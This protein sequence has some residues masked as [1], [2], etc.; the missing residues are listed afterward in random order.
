MITR[1]RPRRHRKRSNLPAHHAVRSLFAEALEARQLLTVVTDVDPPAN[2]HLAPLSAN[3]A[4]TFD[5][6]IN[7]TTATLQ[8]FSIHSL[9]RGQLGAADATIATAGNVVTIDP[10]D[11][12]AGELVQ[13]TVTSATQSAAGEAATPF[14][15]QFRAA[16]TSGGAV[17][18]P[19]DPGLGTEESLDVAVGDLDGDGD[20]DAF[21]AN[22][23]VGNRVWLNDRGVFTDSGQRLGDHASFGVALGDLDGDGDL[24]A[25]VANLGQANR[26]WVN[27]GGSFTDSGQNLGG[28][29]SLD[30]ALG[31]LDGDGDLDAFVANVLQG[32]RVWT[33]EGGVFSS[34]Q[35]LGS[36]SSNAVSLGD[37]D[38]DGDLDAFVANSYQANRVW[39]NDG[40]QFTDSGQT[41]GN[42]SSRSVSLG[43]VDADG[44]LD[45]FVANSYQ[46]SRLWTNSSG[47]F[48]ESGQSFLN[49]RSYGVSLGDLDADGD[50]DALVAN[51]GSSNS[52]L[53]NDAGVFTADGQPLGSAASSGI[54]LGDLDLDGDLDAV[55]ANSGQNRVWLN[56]NP[57]FF[58]TPLTASL[59]EGNADAAT[60]SFTVT[61]AFDTR[62][63]ASVDFAVTPTGTDPAE[64]D[65][66]GGAVLPNGTLTFSDG[67]GTL[68]IDIQIAGDVVLENDEAFLVTLSNPVGQNSIIASG[69]AR[70]LIR[71]DDAVDLGDL[72][73][74]FPTLL[75]DGGA[76]HNA[77]GP[78]LGAT[79]DIDA[80]GQPAPAADGDDV[81]GT[82]DDEDGVTFTDPPLAGQLTASVTVNASANAALDAWIDFDGDQTFG[83]A[84]EQIA[85][86]QNVVTG[87][88]VVTFTVPPDA[89]QGQTFARFRLSSMGGLPPNGG[90]PDGE[91]EDH[92]LTI[93]S[94]TGSGVFGD[95]GQD[96][97]NHSTLA[98]ALG[99]LD[100]D[101]DLDAFAANGHHE[102]DRVWLNDGGVFT[103]SG[104]NLGDRSNS[105]VAL[106]DLDGDGDLDALVT[107]DEG[108]V[109]WFNAAGVFSESGQ[110]LGIHDSSSVAL[111][112]LDADGDLDAF[113][114]NDGQGNQLWLNDGGVFSNSGQQLGSGAS[115]S[116]SLG[117][118]DGDG[119]LDAFVANY[120][121][122]NKIWRNDG[123]R[124]NDSGQ[125]L[126]D[127]HSWSAAL[128]DLDADGDLDA[129]VANGDQGIRVWRN[130][131]GVF[132]DS[133]QQL[134]DHFS[135]DVALGD[136]DGDGDL[137]AFLANG[138]SSDALIP[139][140]GNRVLLNDNGVFSDF[141]QPLGDH[142]S[143]GV[144]LG[145]LDGDGDLDAFS[146]NYY[147]S[148]SP[149]P[150]VPQGN[151][152]WMN[153]QGNALVSLAA[154]DATK[155]EGDTGT[156]PFVFEV[157]RTGE[158][159]G[160]TAVNFTVAGSGSHPADADD[161]GGT[162]PS[163]VINF[164]TGE[165]TQI[166]TLQVSGDTLVE[167]DEGLSVTLSEA[168]PTTVE[169]LTSTA[170]GTIENDDVLPATVFLS[171]NSASIL[172]N[173][174]VATLTAT[175][176]GPITSDVAVELGF[177][178]TAT[179]AEDYVAAA[180][181]IVIPSGA[182]TGETTLTAVDD[183]LDEDNET[184][185]V[186]I[187]S[188]T[189]ALVGGEPQTTTILD[190]DGPRLLQVTTLDATSSGF[191]VQFSDR[192]AA[193]EL[194]LYDSQA[195]G[196]GPADILLEGQTTGAVS[197]SVRLLSPGTGL[198]FV[199]SG[200]PLLPDIYTVT[201]RSS[202]NG[203]KSVADVLLDG[204]G[205]GTAGGD[206]VQTFSI[207][208]PPANAVTVSLPDF[209][210]GPGQEINLP[211]DTTLGIPLS[212]SEA[213]GLRTVNLQIGYDTSLLTFAA[214]TVGADMPA[215]T[216]VEMNVL[217]NTATSGVVE[218]TLTSPTE[219]PA[220]SQTL[221]NLQ[222]TVPL[223][224]A[225]Q[226]Y[227]S[228]QVLDIARLSATGAGGTPVPVVEDD[229]LHLVT[230]FG[231][232]SA[233]G[234]INASDAAQLGRVAVLS[235]TGFAGTPLVDPSIA[236]DITGNGRVNAADASFVA[237]FAALNP[238]PEIP[239][240]PDGVVIAGAVDVI[241]STHWPSTLLDEV[242]DRLEVKLLPTIAA[243][244]RGLFD[245]A[246]D[247][248]EPSWRD[249]HSDS[250]S[251]D[252]LPALDIAIAELFG[253]AV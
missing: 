86:Q 93:G 89:R 47:V 155:A 35:V 233:N 51:F 41:L 14:V 34:G 79:R 186:A 165:T 164:A 114:A 7:P 59:P 16:A 119:D 208:A 110:V 27:D 116:V 184:I 1:I 82:P 123:G 129:F 108:N 150:R 242:D 25:L 52:V 201:L 239:P 194:N 75:A 219:L 240:I 133:G 130:E 171:I 60:F 151:R 251:D 204:D 8:S 96:L 113:I 56:D 138:H 126:G 182:T 210:R 246:A 53:L 80:D 13:A 212:I 83:G 20:L 5:Q 241:I 102:G 139:S 154:V 54:A 230:Y 38:A 63:T 221:V 169:I 45:A 153:L 2:S 65:D 28:Q 191:A 78:T 33:N 202:E 107:G 19:G 49:D 216:T 87:D 218:I 55:V 220:G 180:T 72:P 112:D 68:S 223:A 209:A 140:S 18:R 214:A 109:V 9:Q 94:P 141:G 236:A 118:L 252:E 95:S 160:P 62:G 69:T 81:N 136:L 128:G 144:A 57:S 161:F 145:D 224:G 39:L 74:P 211:A 105:D 148:G 167:P 30:V 156:T 48:T 26:V 162:L 15:W 181:Q 76:S 85:I 73:A 117:D 22:R 253:R 193:A 71:N 61:R 157:T 166:I 159:S 4:T 66:F 247:T 170:H 244:N 222:A 227:G 135:F 174:G 189:N 173:R 188:A 231:D 10:G 137:D 215:G 42:H 168:T 187:T 70:G 23:N 90:A 213:A 163:G 58:I 198:I 177:S 50:L 243:E 178:G 92:L 132:V 249:A 91:V 3:I 124:F 229:A 120:R 225:S 31:D 172:E 127:H 88:N 24:D 32:N 131:D 206:F 205:D 152:V 207:A 11:F 134:G 203:L 185:T 21:V 43:D 146:G 190:D 36:S 101:G 99:D 67:V 175:L 100:G 64:P 121:Q 115:Q 226:I 235:D 192:L 106:G 97:G 12:L 234:R 199:K 125:S 200:G 111:G 46:S 228:H 122:P 250:E 84:N 197:G 37:V 29:N 147:L 176:S 77:T 142:S 40:G 196:L 183:L 195:A 217:N 17:F 248:D 149:A 238:V 179:V 103:A 237:Q 44:D 143:F 6:P 232:V 104:Q 98:V 245:P 158:L